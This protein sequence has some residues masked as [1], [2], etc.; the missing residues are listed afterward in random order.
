MRN[1]KTRNARSKANTVYLEVQENFRSLV[2]RPTLTGLEGPLTR[3]FRSG[4]YIAAEKLGE[5]AG[6][7]NV[8]LRNGLLA[9]N[10]PTNLVYI[11]R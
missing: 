7:V 5:T 4:E 8:R 3:T 11:S 1:T 6:H 10:I 2:Y 9:F